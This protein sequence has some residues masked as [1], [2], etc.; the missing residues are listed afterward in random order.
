MGNRDAIHLSRKSAPQQSLRRCP[1]MSPG[2]AAG[3]PP[4]P[5]CPQQRLTGSPLLQGPVPHTWWLSCLRV[6]SDFSLCPAPQRSSSGTRIAVVTPD[7]LSCLPYA[8]GHHIHVSHQSQHMDTKSRAWLP[9]SQA[10]GATCLCGAEAASSLGWARRREPTCGSAAHT[11]R[12]VI[13]PICSRA[14]LLTL[15][16]H[17]GHHL[18]RPVG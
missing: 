16:G 11:L 5:R 8:E 6:K 10:N 7:L 12:M 18:C 3:A 13:K 2:V 4:S 14:H 17:R 15:R 9:G 1:R